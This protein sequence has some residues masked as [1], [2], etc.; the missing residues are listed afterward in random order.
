MDRTIAAATICPIRYGAQSQDPG[1]V[2]ARL[3]DLGFVRHERG[4][5]FYVG[6]AS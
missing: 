4:E 6:S 2:G 3:C 1:K 5:E